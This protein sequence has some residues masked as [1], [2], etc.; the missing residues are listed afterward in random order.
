MKHF[1]IL[2]LALLLPIASSRAQQP[3]DAPD[4]IR[5]KRFI[6]Q[7]RGKQALAWAFPFAVYQKM[8]C[9]DSERLSDMGSKYHCRI[10]WSGSL[11]G[12]NSHTDIAFV[13]SRDGTFIRTILEED[14]FAFKLN[15][16]IIN[17]ITD[18]FID[19][20]KDRLTRLQLAVIKKAAEELDA[21]TIMD[22]QFSLQQ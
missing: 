10:Y 3:T 9:P 8:A 5:I 17:Q 19:K 2:T 21:E 4:F 16:L 14:S 15:G 18:A 1:S 11:D 7:Q 6:T 22:I 13:F 12:G 20:F